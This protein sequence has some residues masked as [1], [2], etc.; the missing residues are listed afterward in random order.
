MV[1]YTKDT[2]RI[3]S[4]IASTGIKDLRRSQSFY[5]Q[6]KR[7]ILI[8]TFALLTALI[9]ASIYFAWPEFI[10]SLM[11]P[12]H[13]KAPKAMEGEMG[14]DLLITGE[15]LSRAMAAQLG[16]IPESESARRAFNTLAGLW[17][18]EPLSE[19]SD[20]NR[21]NGMESAALERQLRLYR[22]SGNLGTL[23]RIDYPAALELTLPG[24]PG[25]RFISLLGLENE[26]LLVDPPIAGRRSLVFSELERTWSGQGFLLWKDPLNLPTRISLGSKGERIKRLQD[27]LKV[28]GAYSKPSTGVF[29]NDTLSAVKGFQSSKGIEQDG[30]VGEQTLMLLYHSIDHYEMP[31]LTVARR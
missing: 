17:N 28:A 3:S 24:I 20:L 30:I 23:L 18:V 1:G 4:R 16:E 25:K 2:L 9:V 11:A 7:L 13:I 19:S 6:R 14:K 27:L 21:F 8:P 15:E 31:R 12:K 29:D 5:P 22:F 26:E 10:K